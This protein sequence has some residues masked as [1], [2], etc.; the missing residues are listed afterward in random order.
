MGTLPP[1][2]T[3]GLVLPD[4]GTNQPFSTAVQN[5][6]FSSIDTAVG[7]DRARLAVIEDVT[8]PSAVNSNVGVVPAGTTAERD[9]FWGVPGSAA[10]RVALAAKGARWF[11]TEK[12]YEQ[13]YFAQFDDAGAGA[14]TRTTHGWKPA[15]HLS[16]VPI[17]IQPATVASTGTVSKRGN[18]IVVTANAVSIDVDNIFTDDFED[19]LIRVVGNVPVVGGVILQLRAAGVLVNT[20]TYEL[21]G[22]DTGA[23]NGA[24][25]TT[26]VANT[27]DRFSLTAT[28]GGAHNAEIMLYRPKLAQDTLMLAHTAVGNSLRTMHGQE[29]T[30][31]ARDGFRIGGQSG[32]LYGPGTI[33]SIFGLNKAN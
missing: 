15:A 2:P 33:V 1:T 12:G 28:P 30:A 21:A 29:K 7:A 8:L 23:A 27:A 20:T 18:S 26:P 4:P 5:G 11:N 13:Q 9:L 6:W 14:F 16:Q 24:T 3:L 19:Y 25:V 32:A 22:Y 31:A 17:P 10:A